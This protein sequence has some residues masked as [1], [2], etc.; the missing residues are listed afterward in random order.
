MKL[1]RLLIWSLAVFVLDQV[2]KMWVSASLA[3]GEQIS[4]IPGYFD[5]VHVTN[6]G[7]AFGLF[8]TLGDPYRFI[9]LTCI[10]IVAVAV[11]VYYY[12]TI[13][14]TQKTLQI[15]LALILGG[16]A[17]NICDR[18]IHGAVVDFLS[19]HWQN[20]W[21]HWELG[22]WEWHFKLEWP[23]FNVADMAIS[24]SVIWLLVALAR[25]GQGQEARG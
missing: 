16:A 21:V 8:S 24:L 14:I 5:L 18:V 19:F 20:R 25:G 6:R 9:I 22:S 4:I 15:P 17:G 12:W 3:L 11:I 2:T 10:S 13:P 1:R 7:A 23:A